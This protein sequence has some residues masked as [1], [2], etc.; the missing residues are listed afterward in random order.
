MKKVTLPANFYNYDFTELAKKERNHILKTRYFAFSLLQNGNTVKK[1]AKFLGKSSRMVHRWINAFIAHGIDGL[2]D[3]KGRGRKLIL[4]KNEE[5]ILKDRLNGLRYYNAR[6]I[7]EQI[8][9]LF[10][11]KTTLPTAYAFMKRNDLKNKKIEERC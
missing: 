10:N 9:K 8:F 7:S 3:K 1:T 4:T 5:F 2:K 11:K 6:V